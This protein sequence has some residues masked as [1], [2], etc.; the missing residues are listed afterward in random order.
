MEEETQTK[1][2]YWYYFT[3]IMLVVIVAVLAIIGVLYFYAKRTPQ[4]SLDDQLN[5]AAKIWFDEPI[6]TEMLPCPWKEYLASIAKDLRIPFEEMFNLFD[7]HMLTMG[8][9]IHTNTVDATNW[10]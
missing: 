1:N 7:L 6:C 3:I 5:Y 8:V 4:L 2:H 10:L 9:N